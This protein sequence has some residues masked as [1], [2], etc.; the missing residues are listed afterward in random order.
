MG[1]EQKHPPRKEDHGC[2]DGGIKDLPTQKTISLERTPVCNS[3]YEA[4]SELSKQEKKF[5]G[6]NTVFNDR[7]CLFRYTEENY[8]RYRNLDITVGTELAKTNESVKDNVTLYKDWNK[9]LS[10]KLK[11]IAKGIKDAKGKFSD[12]KKAACD[13]DSCIKD[14]CNTAQ[15]RALTGKSS[16]DCEDKDVIDACKDAEKTLSEMVCMPKALASDIDSIFK[17]AHDVVGIQVFTNIDTLEPLQKTL[18]DKAKDFKSHIGNVV[19]SRETDMKGLQDSLIK[20]VEEITKAAMARNNAR[21]NFEGYYD[22]AKY[23]CC[24]KCPCLKAND[25]KPCDV[26]LKDSEKCICRICEEVK[27]AFCCDENPPKPTPEQEAY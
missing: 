19:K 13:L 8:R 6:E 17:A 4:A 26:R 18:D 11:S 5:E 16:G 1:Y 22:A 23:L 21:A 7:K 10:E 12:L 20:S 15:R 27:N 3:L 9:K 2:P 25:D 14:S 24:P